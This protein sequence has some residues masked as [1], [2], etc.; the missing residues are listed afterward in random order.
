MNLYKIPK[1]ILTTNSIQIMENFEMAK[2]FRAAAR[3]EMIY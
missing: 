2:Y 3:F 1:I